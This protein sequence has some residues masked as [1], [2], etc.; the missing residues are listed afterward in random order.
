M[1]ELSGLE[2]VLGITFADKS[3]LLRAMVHRSYLNEHPGFPFEDNERLEF[4]GDAVLGFVTGEY[5]YHRC[6][7]LAEGPLTSLR[8]ALVRR[9]TLAQFALELDL[10]HHLRMGQGEEAGGGRRRPAV[11]CATLEAVVG[12]IYLDQGLKT[13][14]QFIEPRIAPVAARTLQEQSDKD[15]KSRLQELAQGSLHHTPHY[16]TVTADGPDHA[17]RFT[18]EV[19]VGDRAYG[20]GTGRSKQEAAQNAAQVALQRIEAELADGSEPAGELP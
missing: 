20:R 13:V 15:H 5:L 8:S 10:G 6:P 3:L 16:A 12:A 2:E 1:N 7:E 18:V 9:D 4:L 17:K 19:R 11:L 14:Q